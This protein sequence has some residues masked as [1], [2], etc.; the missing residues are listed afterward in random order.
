MDGAISWLTVMDVGTVFED[1]GGT[2]LTIPDEKSGSLMRRSLVGPDPHNL[3][4]IRGE[5]GRKTA[6]GNLCE[7]LMDD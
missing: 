6:V 5:C 1:G 3:G 4:L 2:V 7:M